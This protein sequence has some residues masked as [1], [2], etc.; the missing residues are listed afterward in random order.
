VKIL[1][2]R[3][4]EGE[5]EK[6][7]VRGSFGGENSKLYRVLYRGKHIPISLLWGDNYIGVSEPEGETPRITRSSISK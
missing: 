2:N 1:E 6:E 7:K 4:G 5:E 3:Q